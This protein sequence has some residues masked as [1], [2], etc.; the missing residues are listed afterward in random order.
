MA[1]RHPDRRADR[2]LG[3][4][5][6]K[7]RL[8]VDPALVDE[9]HH[10]DGRERL[11]DRAD[12]VHVVGRRCTRRGDVGDP[13]DP[14]PDDLAVAKDAGRDRRHPL[15]RLRRREQAVELGDGERLR[16]GRGAQ[17]L[18]NELERAVDVGV[19]EIEMGDGAD[20]R[21]AVGR[22]EPDSRV[23]EGGEH[24][25]P[26]KIEPRGVDL[27]EVRLDP[28]E[29]DR[30]TCRVPSL[31]EPSG[32]LVVDREPVDVMVEGVERG[33]GHHAGLAHG[34]SEEE[35][36]P[37]G[38]LHQG[39]GACQQGAERAAETL[40][41]AQRDGVDARADRGGGTP[42][43]TAA[44]ISRAPSMCTPSPPARAAATTASSS[45]SGHTRP[46]ATLCVFS[47]TSTT[48]RWSTTSSAVDAAARD[49]GRGEPARH[50]GKPDGEQARVGGGA[51]EL[52]DQDVRVLLGDEHVA[53]TAVQLQ[54]DLVRHRRRREE[55]R[56][57]LPEQLRHP[58]L[59]LVDRRVLAHLLVPDDRRRDRGA[60]AWRRAGNG[61][62]AKIDHGCPFCTRRLPGGTFET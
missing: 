56:P 39:G 26:R 53:G 10:E 60:H 49:L 43:A 8:E 55:E 37:P 47:S 29:L 12:P 51:T 16:H 35:L 45:S 17:R 61:V 52:V 28:V 9:L 42:S 38:G 50:P 59:Q 1:Q 24:V 58:L 4:V 2:C 34:T 27:D 31:R 7:R 40:R 54:G 18:G 46:P 44:F 13:Q 41:E 30:N 48:G 11:R 15:L 25:G 3:Q 6:A 57:L 5:R 33:G 23:P 22:R 14:F 36:L 32:P 20:V 62:G 21:R 19:V